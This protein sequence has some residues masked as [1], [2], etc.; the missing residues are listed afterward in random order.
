[1]V[2]IRTIIRTIKVLQSS[3]SFSLLQMAKMII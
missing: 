1:M 2:T 3:K